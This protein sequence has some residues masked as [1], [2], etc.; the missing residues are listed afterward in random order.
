V[1]M[2]SAPGE[3][4]GIYYLSQMEILKFM[5]GVGDAPIR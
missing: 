1:A 4:T 3:N 2:S 5:L